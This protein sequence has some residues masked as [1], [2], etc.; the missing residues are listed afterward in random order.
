[1]GLHLIASGGISWLSEP[2]NWWIILQVALGLGMV[3]FVH[4]LGHFAVAKWC[5][6]KCEKFYLGFDIGG[7]KL[8][9]FRWGETEYGIGILPLGGYVKMLGQDDN[10]A[11]L[12]EEV[13]RA[14]AATG[15]LGLPEQEAANEALFN[16]RSYLA[17]SVPQRIAIISAGV[18]M[19]VIFAFVVATIA[20]SMGVPQA[21]CVVGT[22]LPGEAAW[23]AG[24]R[25]GDR[26]VRIGDVENPLFRDLQSGVALGDDIDEGVRFVVERPGVAKRVEFNLVPDRTRLAPMIGMFAASTTQLTTPPVSPVSPLARLGKGFETKDI[27]VAMDG[28]PVSSPLDLDRLLALNTQAATITVL[29]N[30]AKGESQEVTIEVPPVP[31]KTLGLRMEMGPITAVQDGSP[32]QRVGIRKG[33]QIV[34]V[35]GQKVLDPLALPYDLV[36]RAG[37]TI[38]LTL[39]RDGKRLDFKVTLRRVTGDA[40]T[41]PMLGV[42]YLVPNRVASVEPNSPVAKAG[43]RPGSIIEKVVLVPPSEEDQK[44]LKASQSEEEFDLVKNP[45]DWPLIFQELQFALPGTK[46]TL[47]LNGSIGTFT[48]GPIEPGLANNWYN[49]NRGLLFRQLERTV[50]GESFNEALVL[51][52]RETRYSLSLVF[53]FLR[54]IVNGQISV[55]GMG[56]PVAIAQAAGSYASAGWPQ[57]LLFLALLSA[58]LAVINILPIPVLDGGHIVFLTIEGLSGKPVSERVMMAFQYA[59]LLFLMSLMAFVL[60]LDI[61][62]IPRNQ[63]ASPQT[64]AHSAPALPPVGLSDRDLA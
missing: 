45:S 52:A 51:G 56:G 19:N 17:K 29:R 26:V 28:K 32:A 4:E 47:G 23:R 39:M 38:K 27:V 14:R 31:I 64:V 50:R 59:G 35:D 11:R 2:A 15:G 13:E 43:I 7:L 20:Y 25:T 58:N 55:K 42:A 34:A 1:M 60:L 12:R 46:V 18:I 48:V 57:F 36:Q 5:G 49:P 61:G 41:I 53:R 33:D 3:I 37:K 54:K 62:V 8:G 16:P 6:V 40:G 24:L 63:R 21:D 10:P 44:K 30:G 9:K 22:V